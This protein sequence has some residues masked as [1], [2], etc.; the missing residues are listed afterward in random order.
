MHWNRIPLMGLSVDWTELREES[1]TLKI[2]KWKQTERQG[3][4]I[5]KKKE[6]K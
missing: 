5:M 6:E 1:V 2:C 4:K 3:E